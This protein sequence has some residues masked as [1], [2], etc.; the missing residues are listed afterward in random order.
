[1]RRGVKI[2]DVALLTI[3]VHILRI[4]GVE[5]K[6]SA[7]QKGLSTNVALSFYNLLKSKCFLTDELSMISYVLSGRQDY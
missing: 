6:H 5:C 4:D 1:M 7:P 2:C 3:G